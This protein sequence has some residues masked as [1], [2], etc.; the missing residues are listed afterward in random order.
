M[1]DRDDW[2]RGHAI[3]PLTLKQVK[4][5]CSIRSLYDEISDVLAHSN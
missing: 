1:K 4:E 2:M 3:L 5:W